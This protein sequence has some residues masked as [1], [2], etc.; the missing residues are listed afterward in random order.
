M[1]GR[2]CPRAG[3]QV[4]GGL[5]ALDQIG[6][7]RAAAS[8]FLGLVILKMIFDLLGLAALAAPAAHLP[9]W[10][11]RTAGIGVTMLAHGGGGAS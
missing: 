1:N 6:G 7:T 3:K 8:D 9:G 4:R 2:L 11:P 10:L 5:K